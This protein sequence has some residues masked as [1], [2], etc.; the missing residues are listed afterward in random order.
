MRH[1]IRFSALPALTLLASVACTDLT[2]TP[3]SAVAPGDF[4]RNEAEV[5]AGLAAVYSQ[6]RGDGALW[7]YYNLSEVTTDEII[8]P[9]RGPDWFDNGRWL[10]LHRQTWSATSPSG[11]DDMQR[12]WVD[13][14]RGVAYANTLLDAL[15]RVD[16]PNEPVIRAEVRV[17]RGF[18]YYML[19]DLFGG[20]PL[21]I[22]TVV[23][24]RP[25]ATRD[26][27]F[28]FIE[29]ELLAVRGTLPL[30]RP[31]AE[32]GRLTR[33]AASAILANM[34]L[35][36]GVFAK[37][38]GV[39]ATA[40]N[41]CMTVTV[42]GGI[43]ACQA[44]VNF[45]DSIISSG[46]YSLPS[47]WR[48]NFTANNDASPEIIMVAKNHNADGLGLNLV[49]RS[50]HYNQFTP[51]PWNG[52]STIAET[53]NAFD[54][55][56]QRR[57]IFLIGQQYNLDRLAAGDSVAV[58]RRPGT[59]APCAPTGSAG[60]SL[61]FTAT[62]ADATSASEAEGARIFKYPPDPAH[63]NEHNGNDFV[64]F[65]LAEI[66]M[67]RAEAS[68]KLGTGTPLADINLLRARVFTVPEPIAVV[69]DSTILAE[70]LFEFTGEAKRR[71]DLIRFGRYTTWTEASAGGKAPTTEPFRIL[72]PIPQTQLDAN[73]LLVQ[74]NGYN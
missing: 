28:R 23:E 61:K 71:Q 74:N 68:F 66:Y 31:A 12:G 7:G 25:R 8:V 46:L 5:I 62:I 22:N 27:L 15:D 63:L 72:M 13:S 70:R 43:N 34:Y 26:S 48:S 30:T 59:V 58:C 45:A 54:A 44:A 69:N 11:L 38:T 20:V 35:N 64:F 36:A 41:S 50:M 73:P 55:D 9:T 67:I 14:Y 33:G 24:D 42:T 21:A 18:Y 65:R 3:K 51:T 37:E 60:D 52:F 29:S 2:E 19:M 40:Y 10:E 53:Y 56:D 17:L 6:L 16:V 39:S 32:H 4:Y 1:F 47:N 57:Q 49:M